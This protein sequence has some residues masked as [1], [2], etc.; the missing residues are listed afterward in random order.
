MNSGEVSSIV[1]IVGMVFTYLGIT[2]VDSTI[3]TGAVNGI[4]AIITFG[5]A[6]WSWYVHR[7]SDNTNST[8]SNTTAY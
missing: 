2:S 5:A 4:I 6:I 7:T 8:T 3:I 1:A